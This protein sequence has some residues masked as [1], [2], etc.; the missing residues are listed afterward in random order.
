M[1]S[2]LTTDS[3]MLDELKYCNI[4]PGHRHFLEPRKRRC[5]VCSGGTVIINCCTSVAVLWIFCALCLFPYQLLS[6]VMTTILF[7]LKHVTGGCWSLFW[8]LP[9]FGNDACWIRLEG[10][11]YVIRSLC[12]WLMDYIVH[13][14]P[15]YTAEDYYW[16]CWRHNANIMEKI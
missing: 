15:W 9:L 6:P 7:F 4:L 1:I 5:T 13:G 10:I 11:C 2:N 14:A 8:G 12:R 16:S 3:R